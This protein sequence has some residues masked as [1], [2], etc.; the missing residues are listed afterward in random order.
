M[1][2]HS[3]SIWVKLGKSYKVA[4]QEK[5]WDTIHMR[6]EN[7]KLKNRIIIYKKLSIAALFIA[8]L[9]VVVLFYTQN[10]HPEV[11]SFA[12]KSI[13]TFEIENWSPSSG[14]NIYNMS[15]LKGLKSVYEGLT[16]AENM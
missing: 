6:L 11:N 13:D 2:K 4:P 8:V 5:S 10:Y 1:N 15:D 12:Q 3:N 7:R 16:K 9:G 14:T